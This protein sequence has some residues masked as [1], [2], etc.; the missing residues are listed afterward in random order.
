MKVYATSNG[1]WWT[2]EEPGITEISVTD[3]RLALAAEGYGPEGVQN[4]QD[5]DKLERVIWKYGKAAI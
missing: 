4:W 2:G 1:D 5:Q 3:L